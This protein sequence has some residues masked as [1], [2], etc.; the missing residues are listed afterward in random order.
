M[1]A[2]AALGP[3]EIVLVL[4]KGE[5]ARLGAVRGGKALEN[6]RSLAQHLAAEKFGNVS[7]GIRH[8][9]LTWTAGATIK[10]AAANSTPTLGAGNGDLALN[11]TRQPSNLRSSFGWQEHKLTTDNRLITKH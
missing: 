8:K 10:T 4:G 3:G 6:E 11:S 1:I 9:R 5:V 2:E 7:N